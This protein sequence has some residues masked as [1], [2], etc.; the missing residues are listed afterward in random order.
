MA[1]PLRRALT[2]ALAER[3]RTLL[4][5]DAT[6]L[7]YVA[8]WVRAGLSMRALATLL[9]FD[10]GRSLSRGFVSFTCQ[11]LE[12]QARTRIRAARLAARTAERHEPFVAA[13]IPAANRGVDQT[14]AQPTEGLAAH[15]PAHIRASANWRVESSKSAA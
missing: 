10:V 7:D 3:A 2:A 6:A 13:L 14:S 8:A 4:G 12:P 5:E 15:D 11:R 9:A 1:T